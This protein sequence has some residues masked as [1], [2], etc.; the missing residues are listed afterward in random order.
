MQKIHV[1]PSLA[2]EYGGG[3]EF[4]VSLKRL[5]TCPD[6]E[7]FTVT[8]NLAEADIVLFT[9][10]GL[11]EKI[12]R[13]GVHYVMMTME[14]FTGALTPNLVVIGM[15]DEVLP[16]IKALPEITVQRVERLAPPPDA[17]R[18]LVIDDSLKNCQ[19]AEEQLGSLYRLTVVTTYQQG[20]DAIKSGQFDVVLTDLMLPASTYGM[21]DKALAY[22][23]QLMPMG[24]MLALIAAKAGVKRIAVVTMHSHHDHPVSAAFTHLLGGANIEGA[25]VDFDCWSHKEK[26]WKGVIERLFKS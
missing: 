15:W 12:H 25:R 16:I 11:L 10:Y 14:P 22:V 4:F 7:R 24:L 6:P 1:H 19:G 9:G 8:E 13:H 26:N 2:S 18:V 3:G 20:I 23:G 17:L 21:L 5:V